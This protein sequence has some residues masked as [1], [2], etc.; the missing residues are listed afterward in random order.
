VTGVA[1]RVLAPS[2]AETELLRACLPN[3]APGRQAFESWAAR[4]DDPVRALRDAPRHLSALLPVLLHAAEANRASV[5]RR[6]MTVMRAA[7]THEEM[8]GRAFEAA[9]RDVLG[10]LDEP[11]VVL[12]GVALVTTVYGDWPLRHCHDL[13]L[14]VHEKPGETVHPSGMPAGRHTGLTGDPSF[15]PS[16]DRAWGRT[17]G[18]TVAGVDVAVLGDAD[19]LV[20]V[21]VHAATRLAP[22]PRWALDA[23]WLIVHGAVDWP[24]LLESATPR[25]APLLSPLLGWLAEELEAPVPPHVLGELQRAAS[26]AD[27]LSTELSLSL[28]RQRVGAAGLVRRAGPDR[29]AVVRTTLAPSTEYLRVRGV[30]RRA[31]MRQGAAGLL[32]RRAA[33]RAGR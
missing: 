2:A 19:A 26:S 28:A 30:S 12:P 21:C 7:W 11:A 25:L 3:G 24:T 17:T 20:H 13:D 15:Q 16:V 22:P 14:L 33:A 27:R 4:L 1:L 5:E 10:A 6:L 29:S 31:W 9:C 8:R 18:A 23:W 32:K